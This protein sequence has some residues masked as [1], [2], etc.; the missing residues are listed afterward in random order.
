MRRPRGGSLLPDQV[1]GLWAPDVDAVRADPRDIGHRAAT[2]ARGTGRAVW[3]H[4]DVDVLDV[5]AFPATDYAMPN[6]LQVHELIDAIRGIVDAVDLAGISLGCY[7]PDLDID[8]ACGPVAV[9]I[10]ATA[11]GA[12]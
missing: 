3:L 11:A 2:A 10:L 9:D 6:G 8:G 5:T 12:S 1:P 4:V 7:G